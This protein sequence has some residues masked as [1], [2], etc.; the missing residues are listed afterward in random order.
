VKTV[1]IDRKQNLTAEDFSRDYLQGVCEPV[2]VTDAIQSWPA[3]SKWTFDYLKES[4]GSDV[5]AATLGLHSDLWKLTKLGA[6]I[7]YLDTPANELPGFWI[8][9]K[10]GKPSVPKPYDSPFYLMGW[11]AFDHPE[12]YHDVQPAPHC[13]PDWTLSLNPTLRDVLQLTCERK[14]WG[15]FI[16]P[17]GS[18][19]KLHIDFGHTHAYLAQ[20]QGRKQAV[21]FSPSD[22]PYLYDGQVDPERPDLERFPLYD[23]A[24][25]YE[26]VIERGELLVI[27]ADWW[28]CVRGLDKSITVAHSF[29]NAANFS[30]HL[31][32]LLRRLPTLV[33]VLDQSPGVRDELHVH[34][35]LTDQARAS[36]MPSS[37]ITVP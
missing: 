9:P 23:Q 5:A 25:A 37:G 28:H 33:R 20:I 11:T 8:E 16:G 13:I 35:S 17:E 22:S 27:P 18:L 2:I 14:Y 29:F 3:F 31:T 21:L 7:D 4:Y 10:T 24:T 30:Q 34:W 26:C 15:V 32:E 12:F 6:Y 1:Q 19:S 36:T